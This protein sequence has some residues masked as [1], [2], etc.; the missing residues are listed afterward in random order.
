MLVDEAKDSLFVGGGN[1]E[2]PKEGAPPPTPHSIPRTSCAHNIT[3]TTDRVEDIT[4]DLNE[5]QQK[6]LKLAVV[7]IVFQQ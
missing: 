4:D 2:G 6:G 5:S 7:E 3:P 1:N